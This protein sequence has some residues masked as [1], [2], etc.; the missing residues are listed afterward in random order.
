MKTG[1]SISPMKLYFCYVLSRLLLANIPDTVSHVYTTNMISIAQT[2]SVGISYAKEL[3]LAWKILTPKN[4][5]L[6]LIN[7]PA[8][9]PLKRI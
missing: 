5:G 3:C 8:T 7:I 9:F 4:C 2:C 1:D 6:W